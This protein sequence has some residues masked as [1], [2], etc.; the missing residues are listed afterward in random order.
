MNT[1][2]PYLISVGNLH[3]ILDAVQRAASPDVFNVE[4]LKDLGFTSS[5]D[6]PTP[7]L[8]KYLGLLDDSGR[9]VN[10]YREFMDHN[11]SKHVL[12]TRMRVAFDDLFKADKNANQKTAEQLKGWFKT[13]TGVSDAVAK[14]IATTFKSLATYADFTAAPADLARENDVVD[15]QVETVNEK[16]K[17]AAASLTAEAASAVARAS[18]NASPRSQIGLVY[19][20]EIHLPDTQNVDT[21]RSIFRALREELM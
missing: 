16:A 11:K 3:K 20:L 5:Q 4:F 7:K 14:K 21:Y 6:R 12:A 9:P 18:T 13:K 15:T 1:D 19:R 8:F 17:S 2:I 10:A